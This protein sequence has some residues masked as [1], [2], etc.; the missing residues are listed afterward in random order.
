MQIH[1]YHILI[2]DILIYYKNYYILKILQD[3]NIS[4]R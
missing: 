2:L 1:L 3:Y 4:S